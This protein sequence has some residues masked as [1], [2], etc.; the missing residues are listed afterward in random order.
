M[1]VE[2]SGIVELIE[3]LF[4]GGQML[5]KV[6]GF[7]NNNK[8]FSLDIP[9]RTFSCESKVLKFKSAI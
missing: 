8:F 3:M 5:N 2:I 4:F 6:L 9:I 7:I 1:F